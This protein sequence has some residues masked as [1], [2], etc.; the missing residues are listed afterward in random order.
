MI[1]KLRNQAYAPKWEQ[2]PKWGQEEVKKE[3]LE[4]GI[5]FLWKVRTYL[6]YL[7][8]QKF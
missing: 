4:K 3:T 1:K 5:K 8:S 6:H 7:T 2:A